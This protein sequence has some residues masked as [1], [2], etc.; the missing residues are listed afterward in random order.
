LLEI[1]AVLIVLAFITEY[2]T[3]TLGMGYGTMLAPILIM[4]GYEPPVLVP[5][6]LVSQFLSGLVAGSFHHR[7]LNMDLVNEPQE[8]SSFSVF[9]LT[10]VVGVVIAALSSIALPVW[11][12]ELYIAFVVILMGAVILISAR[13]QQPFSVRKLAVIGLFGAFNK[14][15]SGGGYGPIVTGGQIVS[16]I[17]PR[18]AIAITSVVEAVMC[19]VGFLFY[20]LLSSSMDYVLL[21][22][23]VLGALLA[24]PLSAITTSKV[25]QERLKYAIAAATI[26]LG[27]VTGFWVFFAL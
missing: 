26:A 16:G 23:I 22:G 3:S 25:S 20:F 17:G 14:G 13:A 5:V 1:L 12:V 8:R 6:V 19:A 4:L 27:L 7:L 2:F 18:A 21:V 24:A 10:G 11:F 15:I 9:A